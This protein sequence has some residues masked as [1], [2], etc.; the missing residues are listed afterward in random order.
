M[1]MGGK[2]AGEKKGNRSKKELSERKKGRKMRGR[3]RRGRLGVQRVTIVSLTSGKTRDALTTAACCNSVIVT[4]DRRALLPLFPVLGREPAKKIIRPARTSRNQRRKDYRFKAARSRLD[5]PAEIKC[6]STSFAAILFG[7][8]CRWLSPALFL[9]L[10]LS[11][12]RRAP[13]LA[14]QSS[15]RYVSQ[16]VRE[17]YDSS[18]RSLKQ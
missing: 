7:T 9:F 11:A 4:H 8:S 18:C 10:A 6:A 3:R 2:E 5:S 1:E 12:S 16:K 14:R 13:R 15:P 17:P